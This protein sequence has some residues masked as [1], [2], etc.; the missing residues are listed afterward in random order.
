M[1]HVVYWEF[2]ILSSDT[3]SEISLVLNRGLHISDTV[4]QFCTFASKM[5]YFV[6]WCLLCSVAIRAIG[7]SG[8]FRIPKRI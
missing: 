7:L 5:H 8:P 3:E 1:T 4:P 6:I 2:S